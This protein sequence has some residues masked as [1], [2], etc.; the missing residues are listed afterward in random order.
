MLQMK[1]NYSLLFLLVS[2]LFIVSSCTQARYG[3][4]MRKTKTSKIENI[5]REHKSVDQKLEPVFLAEEVPATVENSAVLAAVNEEAAPETNTTVKESAKLNR[6]LQH[7]TIEKHE[8][9]VKVP[10]IAAKKLNTKIQKEMNKASSSGDFESLL[11]LIL[12]IILILIIL[13]LVFDLIAPAFTG[14]LSLILLILLILW[15][16]NYL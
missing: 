16:I 13:N 8:L 3:S 6:V 5:A 1:S 10:A 11:R 2:T 4:M 9:P 15:L 7:N 12:I 14:I